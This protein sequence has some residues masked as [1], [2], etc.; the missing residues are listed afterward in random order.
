MDEGVDGAKA[1]INFE[2]GDYRSQARPKR[3]G[4]GI[5]GSEGPQN[6][7]ADSHKEGRAGQPG[8][9]D[10]ATNSGQNRGWLSSRNLEFP[11]LRLRILRFSSGRNN[12]FAAT[13]RA[14]EI[15]AFQQHPYPASTQP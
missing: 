11:T 6:Q 3:I 15:A 13:A 1:I 2:D 10:C 9:Q 5:L 12:G 14:I 4:K 7:R 8:E